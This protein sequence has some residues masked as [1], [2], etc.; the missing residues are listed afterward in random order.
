[1]ATVPSDKIKDKDKDK[2]EDEDEDKEPLNIPPR[3]FNKNDY[4]G[5]PINDA[6]ALAEKMGFTTRVESIDG[7]GFF[8]TL[9]VVPRRINFI[10]WDGVITNAY[11][12]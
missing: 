8:L 10:T 6:R 5:L 9:E 12:G 1:M 2:D 7:S 3:P 11:E 4:L